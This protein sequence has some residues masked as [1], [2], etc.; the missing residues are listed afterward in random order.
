MHVTHRLNL[1][2]RTGRIN[3]GFPNLA[4]DRVFATADR[5]ILVIHDRTGTS[6]RGVTQVTRKAGDGGDDDDDTEFAAF[7]ART[8]AGVDDGAA[9]GVEDGTLLVAGGSD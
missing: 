1:T 5:F 2:T 8:N 4:H 7:R 6:R 9:D 3:A